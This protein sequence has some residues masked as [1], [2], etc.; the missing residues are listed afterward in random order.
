MSITSAHAKKNTMVSP[1][2]DDL[3]FD[4]TNWPDL[5]RL[6]V[7]SELVF[8]QDDEYDDRPKRRCAYLASKLR[9]PAFD[10][11][12]RQRILDETLMDDWESFVEKL[13]QAFGVDEGAI[14]AGRRAE[15]EALP[16]GDDPRIFFAE[17][18]RLC[19][20]LSITLPSTKIMLAQQK[21]PMTL[22]LKLADQALDFT[23]YD[24]FR[25][26]MITMWMMRPPVA[27]ATS[28]PSGGSNQLAGSK[29]KRPRCGRCGRKGH[30]A[31]DCRQVKKEN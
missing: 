31:S 17:F 9:G 29:P 24:T 18:D 6:V 19:G 21:M 25:A 3:F 2:S 20:E 23:N 5:A 26:R 15:L 30:T 16:W 13:N 22:R 27:L 10:W 11:F 14:N 4:G 28:T 12:A 7:A 1:G 8:L